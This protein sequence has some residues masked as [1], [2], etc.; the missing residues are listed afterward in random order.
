MDIVEIEG[1][2]PP[3][4]DEFT[5]RYIRRSRPVILRGAIHDWPAMQ[6]WSYGYFKQRFGEREVPVVRAKNGTLYDAA[7]GLHYEQIRLAEYVDGL[8]AGGPND[9]YVVFRVHEVMPEL[10]DDIVRPI[11]CRDAPWLRSRFWFAGPDT[12]GP[13][14]RD[15]PNNLY[16]QIVGHKKF[17]LIDRRSTRRVY[18]HSF[19]SGVPNYSPVDAEAPDLGRY[20]CFRDARLLVAEVGPGDLLYIPSLWWHQ[21]HSVDTS[22]SVNLWWV[23]GPMVAVVKAAELFMRVRALRL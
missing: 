13:L 3:S 4:L 23:R 20:P 16:A 5:A 11:Y 14:H 6:R 21:A 19:F 9:L 2:A 10:F 12:K 22:L 18:R 1:I 15:L 17:I 7:E 8:A